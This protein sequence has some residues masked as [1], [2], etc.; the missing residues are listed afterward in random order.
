MDPNAVVLVTRPEPGLGETIAILQRRGLHPVPASLLNIKPL[1]LRLEPATQLQA[2][3]ITSAA[4]LPALTPRVLPDTRVLAVGDRTACRAR[5]AGFVRV[6]S[7]GGDATALLGLCR[8]ELSREGGPL[9]LATGV[10]QG[11]SLLVLRRY[12]FRVIRRA[13]YAQDALAA[14]PDTALDVLRA[15]R[16]GAILF[17]SGSASRAFARLLPPPLR[18]ALARLDALAISNEAA[19]PIAALPWRHLRVALRPTLEDVLA[20]L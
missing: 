17:M 20:L 11:A 3:L 9:L 6:D 18:P 16:P 4:A 5:E 10:G 12:G 15:C 7:A 8:A 19:A 13:V 2:V 1:E 14:M